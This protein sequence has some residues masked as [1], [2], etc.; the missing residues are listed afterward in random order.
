MILALAE[1]ERAEQLGQA[2]DLAPLPCRLAHQLARPAKIPRGIGC[3]AQLHNADV[4]EL[5]GMKA[6]GSGLRAKGSGIVTVLSA[7]TIGVLVY[8][9]LA[10]VC[11][12]LPG[13]INFYYE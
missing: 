3:H 10:V 6:H 1:I 4:D 11:A 9:P 12:L 7:P 13:R 2:D 5:R 8:G